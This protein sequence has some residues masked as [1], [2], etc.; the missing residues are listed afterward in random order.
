MQYGLIETKRQSREKLD[1]FGGLNLTEMTEKNEFSYMLDMSSDKY[2]YITPSR[3]RSG[4]LAQA[5]MRAVIAP[6]YRDTN[7]PIP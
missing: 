3:T 1:K 7:K 4:I 2:P 5:G 6:Q